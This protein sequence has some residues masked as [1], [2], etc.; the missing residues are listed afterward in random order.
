[1]ADRPFDLDEA[2]GLPLRPCPP[3][4]L[5]PGNLG[6]GGRSIYYWKQSLCRCHVEDRSCELVAWM[7]SDAFIVSSEPLEAQQRLRAV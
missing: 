3:Q 2:A 1:M 7:D 6:G 5:G 4:V